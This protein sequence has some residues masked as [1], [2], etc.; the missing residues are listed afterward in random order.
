L[1]FALDNMNFY[2]PYKLRPLSPFCVCQYLMC[3]GH[4]TSSEVN[5]SLFVSIKNAIVT[6][7]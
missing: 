7:Q 1:T 4:T 6:H 2:E 3:H 5:L